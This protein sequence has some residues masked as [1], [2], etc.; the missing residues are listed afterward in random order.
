MP[1][2]YRLN[3]ET[4]KANARGR[5]FDLF[6]ALLP[7]HQNVW[8]KAMV[9]QGHSYA[10]SP[11]PICGG[12]DRFGFLQDGE[13]TGGAYCRVCGSFP[14]GFQLLQKVSNISFYKA[15]VEVNNY[16]DSGSLNN[17]NHSRPPIQS[18][19][20][21]KGSEGISKAIAKL[22]ENSTKTPSKAHIDYLN[23]RNLHVPN[24]SN[25]LLY[26]NGIPY[27]VDG[28][29]LMDGKQWATYPAIIARM[30]N[31]FGWCGLL[32][33]YLTKAGHKA[34]SDIQARLKALGIDK[35]KY[36]CRRFLTNGM[37][38]GAVRLGKA[39]KVLAICE[40]L[41]TALAIQQMSN[42]F[43]SIAAALTTANMQNID[44]PESVEKVV[45][46][47]DKDRNRAGEQAAYAL[48]ERERHIRPCEILL[49]NLPI[50]DH[51]KGIDW[52][53]V[54]SSSGSVLNQHL[55]LVQLALFK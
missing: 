11:C 30:S 27:Y 52:L 23:S 32:Q 46:F 26:H 35:P 17:T 24:T 15:L 49:P 14:D 3:K 8:F 4:I 12:D 31:G 51:L 36:G 22:I 25:S 33:T 1:N 55:K 53:D 41:E 10:S 7:N 50:P 18:N 16:L 42:G 9:K 34:T 38:G 2:D 28:K 47:A 54:L 6:F 13:L 40:G 21:G 37:Q 5:W 45:I 44:I 43:E 48:F 29:P 19:R 20:Q 39:G